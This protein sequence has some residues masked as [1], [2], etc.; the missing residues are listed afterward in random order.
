MVLRDDRDGSQEMSGKLKIAGESAMRFG[1]SWRDALGDESP[2]VILNQLDSGARRDRLTNVEAPRTAL[3]NNRA[4]APALLSDH[5]RCRRPLRA[6][7]VLVRSRD[8][9]YERREDRAKDEGVEQRWSTNLVADL[10]LVMSALG[11]LARYV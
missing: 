8:R 9:V 10:V 6:G 11:E 5:E 3:A 7:D 1:D 4:G 2:E